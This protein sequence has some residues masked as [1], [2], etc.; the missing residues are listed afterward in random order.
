MD[1]GGLWGCGWGLGW[2]RV[3]IERAEE[4]ERRYVVVDCKFV[5]FGLNLNELCC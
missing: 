2:W 3:L 4:D 5:Q 1:D